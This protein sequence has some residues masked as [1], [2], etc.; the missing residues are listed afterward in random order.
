MASD[1]G[2]ETLNVTKIFGGA[3]A[4]AVP[5]Y[6]RS[7]SW[8]KENVEQLW[9][10][11]TENWSDAGRLEPD[12]EEY[13]LG[14]IVTVG[15][16]IAKPSILLDGQQRLATITILLCVIR[17]AL[18]SLGDAGA[19]QAQL[20][21]DNLVYRRQ[22][23]RT[24]YVLTLNS[25]DKEFF[26]RAVQAGEVIRARDA[27]LKSHRRILKAKSILAS[28]LAD[29]IAGSAV[30]GQVALLNALWTNIAESILLVNVNVDNED[31]AGR[32]FEVLNDRG[33][34]LSVA[35]LM[36]NFLI[37]NA[38][39]QDRMTVALHWD[40]LIGRFKGTDLSAFLRH[41]W[42]SRVE[43]V[44]KKN[45][46]KAIRSGL[47]ASGTPSLKYV[48]TLEADAATYSMLAGNEMP[49]N[50]S[51]VRREL[52]LGFN[53]LR[54]RQALPLLL[55]VAEVYDAALDRVLQAVNALTLQYSV[56]ERNPNMLEGRYSSLARRVRALAG[57]P[58][59]I[60][61]TVLGDL[62][63]LEVDRRPFGEAFVTAIIEGSAVQRY[64]LWEIDKAITGRAEGEVGVGG[65]STVHVDHIY[66]QNPSEGAAWPDA[67]KQFVDRL[68][69]LALLSGPLN[70][71]L[72]NRPFGEKRETY[73][74]SN[75]ATTSALAKKNSWSA[76]DIEQR[77]AE[78][79][80]IAVKVWR[81]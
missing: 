46:Y 81:F 47:T 63:A 79:A 8:E 21:D 68:G 44:S 78:F 16:A 75:F 57:D 12:G 4:I 30:E 61:T 3:V 50:L 32:V 29:V 17:D 7:Y 76:R 9:G 27:S 18:K 34:V 20:I 52:I 72:Q 1:Y 38:S 59:Q 56:T 67:D 26:E 71:A 41:S 70:Q 15:G 25:E 54:A 24:H 66:P 6:Q 69:N 19:Q 28:R 10:D 45:S 48:R 80:V 73:A 74:T 51:I 49:S 23:G 53:A 64:V 58:A 13:F 22:G 42:V 5:P 40:A 60:E 62:R 33:L 65:G 43:D 14:T 35:D 39:D 37:S 2:S 36:R 77:Q 55:A 31:D 11:L